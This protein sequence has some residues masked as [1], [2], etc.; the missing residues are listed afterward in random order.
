MGS[1]VKLTLLSVD[2]PL[3]IELLPPGTLEQLIERGWQTA[4]AP[5]TALARAA[6]GKVDA[7]KPEYAAGD[8]KALKGRHGFDFYV[9]YDDNSVGAYW[10]ERK[11]SIR[12]LSETKVPLAVEE[13]RKFL[14]NLSGWSHGGK[15]LVTDADLKQFEK[16]YPLKPKVY[17]DFPAMQKDS[18]AVV[19]FLDWARAKGGKAAKARDAYYEAFT[20]NRG[21]KDDNPVVVA[22]VK[23]LNE[24]MKD[25]YKSF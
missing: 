12:V 18:K 14:A 22:A 6:G 25:Y 8:M 7:F 4:K 3:A 5:V 17:K 2:I 21:Y 20:G 13:K 19:A 23:A 9:V 11:R 16:D 24:T 15:K 1:S 10:T